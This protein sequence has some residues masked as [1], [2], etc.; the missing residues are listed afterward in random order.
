MRG[1]FSADALVIGAGPA[2]LGTALGLARRGIDVAVLEM[3]DRIGSRRRGETIRFDKEMDALLGA[4]FFEKQTIRKIQ[5]RSY[6]SHSGSR[7]VDR[8]IKNPNHIISWPDFI[9][10][11]ADVVKDAG[12]RVLPASTVVGFLEDKGR[13]AGVRAMVGGFMEE[14]IRAKAVFSCGG[15]GDPASRFLN[16]DR[17]GADM[18]VS[19]KLV[20]GYA[21]PH[22]RFEY[23]FHVHKGSLTIGTIFPR[24][25]D[26]A[27]IILLGI[28]RGRK[29]QAL[30]FEEFAGAHELF[31]KRLEGT[32]PF[33]TL[34]T[35][36]PMGKMIFPCCPR[37]GLVMAGDVLGHVQA[38]GG[39]GIKTSFLLGYTAGRLGA[40]AV[41][42][43][44]WT[45][46]VT[47]VLEQGLRNSAHM[48][49]L[50]RHNLVYSTLRAGIF[51][52]ITSPEAMDR[53]WPV[54]RIALR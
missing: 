13:I 47:G 27:E 4:G 8:T 9:R 21:G 5:K 49:S 45:G 48:R 32:E 28:A 31:G 6:F 35:V 54:L 34:K 42:A 15:C 33:Y 17:S 52:R 39:S 38:R 51:G 7:Q 44:K 53:L 16:I 40:E 29:P 26:E 25:G 23:H 24:A 11:M 14:E 30:S 50:K 46:Q 20:R 18:P 36:I 2:G 10:A 3:Q 1:R 22:D 37:D 19:K 43:G 41:R 12:V